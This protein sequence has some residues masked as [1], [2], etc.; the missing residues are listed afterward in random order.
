MVIGIGQASA[1]GRTAVRD[2]D[3]GLPHHSTVPRRSRWCWQRGIVVLGV[4]VAADGTDESADRAAERKRLIARREKLFQDLVRLEHEQ[5]R[6]KIDRARYT[7]RRE[8][9]LAVARAHLRRARRRRYG[10]GAGRAARASPP[11]RAVPT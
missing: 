1:A 2:D 4:W 11:E 9:L 8:E 3:H 6:G 10:S 5:R 7:A